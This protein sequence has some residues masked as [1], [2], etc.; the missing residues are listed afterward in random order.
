MNAAG[1]IKAILVKEFIQLRRD[2]L[3]FGMMVGIPI[4]QLVLFGFA[5]NS[6]PK[7]LPTGIV[8]ADGSAYT[9]SILSGM[10]NS[11]YF[12]F[13]RGTMTEREAEAA[14]ERG[15]LAFVVTFP[16]DFSRD[17]V[18]GQR[19]QLLLEADATDP[20]ASGNAVGAFERIVESSLREDL[21]GP[22][23]QAS[24]AGPPVDVVVHRLYN[25]EGITR[26]NIVPGLLGVILT[27]TM[28]L[29]TAISLTR[30]AERGTMENLLAMPVRPIE[31][32]IGKITPYIGIGFVQVAIILLAAYFMFQVPMLG[33]FV[34]LFIGVTVFIAANLA[35]GYTFSTIARSQMQ[36]MQMTFF[37]FLPSILL[38]GFMFPFRGMPEWAQW[39]G[40]ALPITHFL[41]I[42]RG[43]LLKGGGFVDILPH[44]WPILLIFLLVST[45][46]L[47]RYRRTLD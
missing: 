26:Y 2:R 9:R 41:R 32:M 22:L 42:V 13:T 20:A 19:P 27:M 12:R 6:D 23:G 47:L 17:L 35:L 15:E 3:T 36:A 40:S 18:R 46:A 16:S 38:S 24:T 30:E 34:A 31:V 28:T 25:P 33:S 39:L 45:V 10:E 44:L 37:F 4:M 29:M 21:T 43:T 5:I 11:G 7:H 14:L 8:G 1:C